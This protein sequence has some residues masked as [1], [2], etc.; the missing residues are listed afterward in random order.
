MSTTH[1]NVL[2]P[3]LLLASVPPLPPSY[4]LVALARCSCAWELVPN[5]S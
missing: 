3:L 4:A 5:S 2:P 1:W